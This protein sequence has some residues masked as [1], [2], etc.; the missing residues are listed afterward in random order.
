[1]R[2]ALF[3]PRICQEQL[4]ELEEP[5]R[6]RADDVVSES[7]ALIAAYRTL[8]Q[9]VQ[10][11]EPPPVQRTAM[12]FFLADLAN[13][14]KTLGSSTSRRVPVAIRRAGETLRDRFADD[15]PLGELARLVGV[16]KYHLVHLF[17]REVGLSPHAYRIH[18]RISRARALIGAGTSP[19]QVAAMTGFCDQSHLTRTFKRVVGVT[20]GQYPARSTNT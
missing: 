2:I 10:Q 18:L 9:A 16:S 13:E 19:G 3:D 14:L 6:S 12:I 1:M 15:L 17:S 20:P 11:G 8:W 5:L 4:A 7:R